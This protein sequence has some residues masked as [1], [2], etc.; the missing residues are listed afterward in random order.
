VEPGH[1]AV[2]EHRRGEP[3]GAKRRH[4]LARDG[5]VSGARSHDDDRT[6]ASWRVAPAHD[7]RPSVLRGLGIAVATRAARERGVGLRR[8]R[9]GEKYR[10]RPVLE[11]LRDDPR[12][13]LWR[14]ARA[15]YRLGQ[16]LT[17]GTVVVY[18]RVAEVGERQ[19]AQARRRVVGCDRARA[20]GVE[21][22][23][24]IVAVHVPHYPASMTTA[25]GQPARIAYLGPPGTFTEEALVSESDLADQ[26]L[27]AM[28]TI[29]EAFVA[30]SGGEVDAAFVPIENS[31]EG[32]VNATIDHLVFSDDLL[33][34]REVV[35]DIHIDLMALP[36]TAMDS[37]TSVVSFPHATA[38]CRRYLREH[39]PE[40]EIG[41]AN[42][43]ADAARAVAEGRLHRTAALA[44]PLAAKLY[45]LEV[46]AHAVEDYG[47]NQT[48]FVLVAP[49]HV[50]EPTG[51][52]QT[53]LV[54]FQRSDRPGSLHAILGQFAARS[55]NL[56]FIES[57]PTKKALGDYCFVVTAE[58]HV[59]DEIL[60]DCLR[61]L[62]AELGAVKF[63]G[64]Y[65]L[66]GTEASERRQELDTKRRESREWLDEI[67]SRVAPR[68]A[69]R[70]GDGG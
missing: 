27:I 2:H 40:V 9:A 4:A 36:G 18:P 57:R 11:E 25:A 65:P 54:C 38:Q 43:T 35:L 6:G 41:A 33:V 14:L 3:V 10:T 47:G 68:T 53:T 63:L 30:V 23:G 52:D 50:P 28:P 46:L 22:G 16:A 20:H 56:T 45:G 29:A 42:S 7:R 48:R 44:P 1:A 15:V 32:P 24:E 39:L 62:R 8:V 17:H 66:P 21:E 13:F 67:R 19:A 37:V 49:R 55:L 31:I 61:E 59:A 70:H 5:E 26:E 58:G 60:G 51:H 64:S 34:Q 12:A 69:A